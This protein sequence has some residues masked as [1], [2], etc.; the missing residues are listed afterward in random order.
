MEANFEKIDLKKRNFEVFLK[1]YC[2]FKIHTIVMFY[3]LD[4]QIIFSHLSYLN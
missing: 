3:C 1:K 4:I 2:R